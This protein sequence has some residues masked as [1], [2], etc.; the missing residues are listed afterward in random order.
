MGRWDKRLINQASDIPSI[1][2]L[3]KNS[4]KKPFQ[5]IKAK[6]FQKVTKTRPH[7]SIPKVITQV[8]TGLEYSTD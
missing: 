2:L 3:L 6:L 5:F 4:L 8:Q 1:I 7:F